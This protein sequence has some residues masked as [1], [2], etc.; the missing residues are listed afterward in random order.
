MK[1]AAQHNQTVLDFLLH[2]LGSIE[3]VMEFCFLNNISLTED[4]VI[5]NGYEIDG[6]IKDT[7]ILNYFAVNGYIP[8]TATTI[9]TDFGIGEMSIGNTFIIR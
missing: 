1:Q 8:A 6:M 5:G 3:S 4:M 2:R 9:N 7:D